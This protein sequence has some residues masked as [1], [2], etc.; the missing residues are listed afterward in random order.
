VPNRFAKRML[1][2]NRTEGVKNTL[3]IEEKKW[4]D[5]GV[6]TRDP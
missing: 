6:R 5:D 3:K 2:E 4:V 1:I